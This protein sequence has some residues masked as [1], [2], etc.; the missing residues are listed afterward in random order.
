MHWIVGLLIFFSSEIWAQDATLQT[1]P[2]RPTVSC[3]ADM[4]AQGQLEVEVGYL[5]QNEP[6]G[7]QSSTPLLIK[8]TLIDDLQVQ[9]GGNGLV[10][11]TSTDSTYA[12]FDD[13]TVGLKYRLLKQS[14]YI[15]SMA[16]SAIETIPMPRRLGYNW[17]HDTL[18]YHASDTYRW[19]HADFNYGINFWRGDGAQTQTYAAL[20]FSAALSDLVSLIGEGS[21][22]S[23]ADP[24]SPHN[25]TLIA[26]VAVSPRSWMTFDAA[27]EQSYYR[28]FQVTSY[29]VGVTVL[30][31]QL[32]IP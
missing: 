2:C 17:D 21:T 4:I 1:Q 30:P 31:G 26:A 24:I 28:D 15:P 32:W 11:D 16:I 19:L 13:V 27:I 12:Y 20:A 9:V 22:F 6:I 14:R 8:L 29:T 23:D 7:Y 5:Y 25:N 18:I 3:T 10:T